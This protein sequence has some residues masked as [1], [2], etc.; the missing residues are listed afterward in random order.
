MTEFYDTPIAEQVKVQEIKNGKYLSVR[1]LKKA[2][3]NL[4][5]DMPITIQR[6]EDIHFKNNNSPKTVKSLWEVSKIGIHSEK[7]I[8]EWLYNSQQCDPTLYELS[9]NEKGERIL[10]TYIDTIPVNT[11]YVSQEKSQYGENVLVLAPHY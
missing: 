6:I 1:D 10:K 9:I 8:S 7:R 3:E 2:L 4:D 11:A 5:D